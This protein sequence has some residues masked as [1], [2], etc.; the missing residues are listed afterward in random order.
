MLGWRH[1]AS[2]NVHV[3]VDLDGSDLQTCRLK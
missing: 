3:G 1:R 2:V